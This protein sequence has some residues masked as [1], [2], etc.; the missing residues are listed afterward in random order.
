MTTE[1]FDRIKKI[2]LNIE[3]IRLFMECKEECTIAMIQRAISAI[4][5]EKIMSLAKEEIERLSKEFAE[6]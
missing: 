6:S 1:E 2:E 5:R 4:G 3:S